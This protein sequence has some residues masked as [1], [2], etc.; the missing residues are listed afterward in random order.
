MIG[1]AL[2]YIADDAGDRSLIVLDAAGGVRRR[3]QPAVSEAKWAARMT[4]GRM[5]SIELSN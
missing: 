1:R 2:Y 4:R 5:S 3:I